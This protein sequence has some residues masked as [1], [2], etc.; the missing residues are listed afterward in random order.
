MDIFWLIIDHSRK[1][2][3]H[4]AVEKERKRERDGRRFS[5][6]NMF[7]SKS[8]SHGVFSVSVV[9]MLALLSGRFLPRVSAVSL[10][11]T[12]GNTY[13]GR[14]RG[15]GR[16]WTYFGPAEFDDSWWT[17]PPPVGPD[18]FLRGYSA[19]VYP[20]HAFGFGGMP[21]GGYGSAHH[22]WGQS[23]YHSPM[24]MPWWRGQSLSAHPRMYGAGGQAIYHPR[25]SFGMGNGGTFPIA[26]PYYFTPP[27]LQG[28]WNLPK[29]PPAPPGGD[30]TGNA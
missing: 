17:P 7:M 5:T 14:G 26:S 11:P 29:N 19:H 20:Q 30:V 10:G 22:F 6:N 23:A 4:L 16:A 18:P 15:R 21:G 25:D 3:G 12:L 8:S 28:D 13:T 1:T 9:A 24:N 2:F 27:P